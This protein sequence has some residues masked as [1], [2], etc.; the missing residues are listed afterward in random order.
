MRIKSKL[1][2][3]HINKN[4]DILLPTYSH[5]EMSK[6][7]TS[8]RRK[9]ISSESPKMQKGM[10]RQKTKQNYKSVINRIKLKNTDGKK[11]K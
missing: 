11:Q 10:L 5:K 9:I 7:Y 6:R 2:T 4:R 8:K 3:F 1:K